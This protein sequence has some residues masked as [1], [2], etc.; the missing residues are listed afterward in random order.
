MSMSGKPAAGQRRRDIRPAATSGRRAKAVAAASPFVRGGRVLV[1]ISCVYIGVVG[2]GFRNEP[3]GSLR[4]AGV[5]P[6][7]KVA[8]VLQ[9]LAGHLDPHGQC[10]VNA[11]IDETVSNLGVVWARPKTAGRGE[12]DEVARHGGV[13]RERRHRSHARNQHRRQQHSRMLGCNGRAEPGG[14]KTDPRRIG[15]SPCSSAGRGILPATADLLSLS[16]ATA[17]QGCPCA[18]AVLVVRNGGGSSAAVF[19]LPVCGDPPAYAQ[20]RRRDYARP[21]HA[22]IRVCHRKDGVFASVPPSPDIA[23]GIS[24]AR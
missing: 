1:A 10:Y 11:L 18:A 3:T 23:V 7:L 9:H 21:M 12:W 24:A 14:R 16:I 19:A 2:I 20:S 17:A 4:H 6:D 5:D 15:G 13:G 8:P 22:G